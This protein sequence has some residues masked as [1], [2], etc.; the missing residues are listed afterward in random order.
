V[1]HHPDDSLPRSPRRPPRDSVAQ[2]Q[3]P[4]PS[5]PVEG[6]IVLEDDAWVCS[7]PVDLDLVKVT[8]RT[9]V[10]DAVR[11]DENCSGR[12]GRIEVD[13]WTADGIKVQ[14]HGAVAHD[15]V[16]ESGYIKCHDVFGE[17]HQDGIQAMG[18]HRLTF[19]NLAV[20]CLG[21]AN[22]FVNRAGARV[23]TPTDVVCERCVLG[24]NSAQTLF[25]GTSVRSGTRDSTICTGRY[26]AIR[27]GPR[28]DAMV[29]D[30]TTV[31]PV[32]DP[33]CADVTGRGRRS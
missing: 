6:R 24:P 20:D 23:S 27:V 9:A 7:G 14:N 15:L 8:M 18:G 28:T 22:L 11:L 32:G 33:S 30:G 4:S 26:R 3:P 17:Y 29:D 2:G 10:D 5:A 12:I 16:V 1:L 21:N 31:L 25:A 13:T 19:R